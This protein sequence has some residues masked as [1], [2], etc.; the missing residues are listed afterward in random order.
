MGGE[1]RA[2][3]DVRAGEG[4]CEFSSITA[5]DPFPAGSLRLKITVNHLRP[6]ECSTGERL[7]GVGQDAIFCVVDAQAE[8]SQSIRARVRGIYFLVTVSGKVSGTAEKSRRRC[9]EEAAEEV[10]GNLF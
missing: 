5:D 8:H 7:T 3:V 10:A 6:K 2:I 9:L 1:V 4:F